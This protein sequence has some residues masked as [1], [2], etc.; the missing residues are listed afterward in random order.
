VVRAILSDI[1]GTTSSIAFVKDVLFP[2]S[3]RALATFVFQRKGEPRVRAELDVVAR[4]AGM[5]VDDL[6]LIEVL[7]SWIDA[8]RK[9][10]A[11]KSL[12]GMIWE[13]G[14]RSGELRAHVY[15]DAVERLR[16]WRAAGH[17]VH[18]YSSGSVRAQQLYFRHSVAGDLSSIFSGHFD[19]EVGSKLEAESYRRIAAAVERVPSE[20][21]YLSDVVAELDAARA[22]GLDTVLLDRPTDYP[23]SRVGADTH[24]HRRVE[25]FLEIGGERE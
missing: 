1:E 15:P 17:L 24:G 9:H 12:Q 8:D 22:A 21:L 19:T 20:I 23:R 2:F 10:R 6:R 18:V 3:R 7:Q 4:E 25:S 5:D 11:L 13:S 16:T 14:Y